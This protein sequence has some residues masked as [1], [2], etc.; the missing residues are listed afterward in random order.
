MKRVLLIFS[1]EEHEKLLK[2]KDGMTW[3]KFVLTLA[4]DDE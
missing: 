3:E 1:D 2:K 4:E